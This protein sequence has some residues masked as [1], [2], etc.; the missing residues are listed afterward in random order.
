GRYRVGGL[1][2]QIDVGADRKAMAAAAP[3]GDGSDALVDLLAREG[4][5]FYVLAGDASGREQRYLR[6]Y[7]LVAL[8]MRNA[9]GRGAL[10]ALLAAQR[11]DPCHP[12]ASENVF[13]QHFRGGI[14]ALSTTWAAFMRNPPDDIQAY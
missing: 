5:D 2:G 7:A 1:G 6:A 8:L 4:R 10:G 9:E 11:A 3:D 13:E 14:D 12:V